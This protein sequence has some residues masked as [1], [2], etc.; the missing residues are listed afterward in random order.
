MII[1]CYNE[2]IVY[3]LPV[4]PFILS[5]WLLLFSELKEAHVV[6]FEEEVW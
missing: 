5:V 4:D 6:G 3:L 1:K 2:Y